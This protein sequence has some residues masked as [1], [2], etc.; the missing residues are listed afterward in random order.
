MPERMWRKSRY[1]ASLYYCVRFASAHRGG[2]VIATTWFLALGAVLAARVVPLAVV[3]VLHGREVTH[4][5]RALNRRRLAFVLRRSAL[6]IAVSRFTRDQ[7]VRRTG[8]SADRVAVVPNGVDPHRF[9]PISDSEPLR[10]RLG[11]QGKQVIMTLAR[12]AKRKGHDTVIRALPEVLASCPNAIYLIAGK[13]HPR[14]R[15]KLR[16]LAEHLG[17]GD[18]VIFTGYVRP[19]DIN[20]FY[21][22]CDVYVMV[23]SREWEQKGDSE[24]FGITYLEANACR[25]PV[26]GANTGG[27]QDAIVDGVTGFLVE[28]DDPEHLAGCLIRLL[29]DPHLAA[30]MGA[31][32]R[33]RVVDELN[34]PRIA[35]RIIS[36][37]EDRSRAGA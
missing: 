7:V 2:V 18:K 12:V 37:L 5:M 15:A 29:H 16:K 4:H 26:V 13:W 31:Q 36:R 3:T 35:A 9:H 11:L 27:V 17:L 19:Q 34:W 8:L 1:V 10:Q 6:N 33:Q 25:K 28:P 32:G 21:S 23:P 24:G 20:Q 22:L 30:T 14:V